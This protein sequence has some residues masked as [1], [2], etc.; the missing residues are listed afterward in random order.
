MNAVTISSMQSTFIML[1]P[2]ISGVV[3]LIGPDFGY[4]NMAVVQLQMHVQFLW[5]R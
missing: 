3:E 4:V 2:L 5:A 1:R